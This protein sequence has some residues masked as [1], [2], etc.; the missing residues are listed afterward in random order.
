MKTKYV[1]LVALTML[2]VLPCD[3]QRRRKRKKAAEK[4]TVIAQQLPGGDEIKDVIM[5]ENEFDPIDYAFMQN[6]LVELSAKDSIPFKINRI[7]PLNEA[8]DR[9]TYAEMK[10][11]VNNEIQNRMDFLESDQ[12]LAVGRARSRG[13]SMKEFGN[14]MYRDFTQDILNTAKEKQVERKYSDIK[15]FETPIDTRVIIKR[16]IDS[17]AF[18]DVAGESRIINIL[19]KYKEDALDIFEDDIEL[20][21]RFRQYLSEAGQPNTN[22]YY[23][24]RYPGALHARKLNY[25][26]EELSDSTHDLAPQTVEAL[27][28]ILIVRN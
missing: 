16:E 7:D 12:E 6:E 14:E 21:R 18:V 17:M 26:I 10:S 9:I 20:G 13:I 19:I 23:S 28:K 2:F 4:D 3:A 5:G 27:K 1:L 15:V 11:K 22:L 8:V 25:L 24:K